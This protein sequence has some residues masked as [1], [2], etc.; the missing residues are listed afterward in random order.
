V[1]LN[2]A[3][4]GKEYQEVSFPVVREQVLQF[5]D[6]IGEDDPLFRDP[7]AARAAGHPEQLAPPTFVT[8]MQIMTSGQVVVDQELG[9]DYSRVVHGEQAYEWVR[10]VF[11]GDVLTA[12]PRI[13]DIFAKKSNEYLVIEAEIRDAG[14][15]RVAVART[16]LISRGTG[17]G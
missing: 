15:E 11:V 5:A 8:K 13:A 6:A 3:L 16:T 17:V 2:Q 7:E 9:L 10:P 4:K 14:G 12:V 1:P